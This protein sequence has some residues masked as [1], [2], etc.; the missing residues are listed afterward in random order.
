[1]IIPESG[2]S[3]LFCYKIYKMLLNLFLKKKNIHKIIIL[4]KGNYVNHIKSHNST[5]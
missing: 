4:Q 1:M 3:Y 2:I 5:L